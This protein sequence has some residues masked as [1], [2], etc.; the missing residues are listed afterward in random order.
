MTVWKRQKGRRIRDAGAGDQSASSGTSE[1]SEQQRGGEKE[2]CISGY[3]R[4]ERSLWVSVRASFP[5]GIEGGRG[6]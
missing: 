6:K 5:N 1:K 4:R 3:G 2:K